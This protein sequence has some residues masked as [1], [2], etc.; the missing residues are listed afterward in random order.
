MLESDR[1]GKKDASLPGPENLSNGDC[2]KKEKVPGLIVAHRGKKSI[3]K[4]KYI[5]EL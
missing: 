5:K 1:K 3:E 2:R 4:N